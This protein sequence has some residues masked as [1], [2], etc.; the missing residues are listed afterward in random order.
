MRRLALAVC[1]VLL[2]I[3]SSAMAGPIRQGERAALKAWG[4]VCGGQ[5]V[6]ITRSQLPAGRLGYAQYSYRLGDENRPERYFDCQ[7]TLAPV[8]VRAAKLCTIVVHEFGHLSGWRARPGREYMSPDGELDAFHSAN[9][10]SVM[11]PRYR[12]AFHRCDDR[13]QASHGSGKTPRNA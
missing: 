6:A 7:I 3:V 13:R 11:F 4:P 5:G 9:A 1:L 2:T 10:R 8:A 12:R